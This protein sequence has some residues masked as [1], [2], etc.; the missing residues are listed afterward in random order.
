MKQTPVLEGAFVSDPEPALVGSCCRSCDTVAF[1]ASFTCPNPRCSRKDVVAAPISRTGR[2][3]SWTTV[4][5]PPPPPFVAPDP[6]VPITVVEVE[7]TSEGIQV[8]GPLTGASPDR[9]RTGMAM[10]TVVEP[11]YT[12]DSGEVIGWKFRPAEGGGDE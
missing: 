2:L 8:V 12:D 5:F 4:H 7:F 3:A 9:L 10:E 6:F 1:P 11:Y